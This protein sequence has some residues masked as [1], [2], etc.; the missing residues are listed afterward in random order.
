MLNKH[1]IKK[2]NFRILS[3]SSC[4]T[5]DWTAWRTMHHSCKAFLQIQK[6]C[7]RW[8]ASWLCAADRRQPD[9]VPQ[10]TNGDSAFGSSNWTHKKYTVQTFRC[11]YTY[12]VNAKPHFHVHVSQRVSKCLKRC[13]LE[14]TVFI[15]L[16]AAIGAALQLC[17]ERRHGCFMW[18]CTGLLWEQNWSTT[19]SAN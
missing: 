15:P 17:R 11:A 3:W 19:S 14:G 10:V 6:A 4:H 1:Q 8:T 12:V 13:G 18:R 9:R 16:E 7:G 5:F 2:H